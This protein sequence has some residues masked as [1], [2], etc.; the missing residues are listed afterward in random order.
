MPKAIDQK[1]KQLKKQ[2][3]LDSAEAVLRRQGL[4]K[5]SISAVAKE[6]R[7]AQGTLYLYF[8]EKEEIIAQLTVRSRKRLLQLF[9]DSINAADNPLE[10]IRNILYASHTFFKEN[11][12][13]HDLV[14]FYEVNAEQ[15]EPQELQQASQNISALV[16]SV[17]DRAKTQ[18]LIRSNLNA[19]EFTYMIWGM[20]NGMV[21][22]V[23]LR[24]KMLEKDLNKSP[25]EVYTSFVDFVIEG[26][27]PTNPA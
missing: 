24:G 1:D 22:L 5:L 23:D 16:V 7:L 4:N 21:Q 10:Q 13:F 27:K 11:K 2:H 26:M 15:E 18:G 17:L 19:T 6:A 25:D 9:H 3:I 12:I 20:S 8:K 14:S